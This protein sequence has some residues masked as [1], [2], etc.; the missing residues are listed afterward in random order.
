MVGLCRIARLTNQF[1]TTIGANAQNLSGLRDPETRVDLVKFFGAEL[2][3]LQRT[4]FQEMLPVIQIS[5]LTSR[6]YLWSFI[7]QDDVPRSP[8]VIEF[9]YQAE[10]DAASLI[11][12]ASEKNLSRCPFHLARSVLYSAVVLIKILASPYVS[13]PKVIVDQIHLAGRTLSSAVKI[14]DD[15]AQRWARH[16]QKL[17]DLR[18]IKRNPPIR[19]RMAASLVYDAIRIMK[20]HVEV[21]NSDVTLGPNGSPPDWMN[22][23]IA[24]G[25]L[26]LDGINWDDLGGLL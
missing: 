6:L 8:V 16:L 24:S 12:L 7:L 4:H 10:K 5:F 11:Q 23:D 19:S 25:L 9:F 17:L 3:A 22:L 14:E 1:T 15:H 26:S 2:D 20:E 18:D 21:V 13:Q